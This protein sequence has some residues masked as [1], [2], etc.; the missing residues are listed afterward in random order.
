MTKKELLEK[1]DPTTRGLFCYLIA[2]GMTQNQAAEYLYSAGI[3]AY[4]ERD[5]LAKGELELL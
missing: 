2:S 1:L 3:I 5:L 4:W